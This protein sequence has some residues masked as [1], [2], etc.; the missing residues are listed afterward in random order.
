MP[1]PTP[2]G[3]LDLP[4]RFAIRGGRAATGPCYGQSMTT[5][6]LFL[7]A[8]ALALA[9]A[10]CG[11]ASPQPQACTGIGCN[12][13][14]QITLTSASAWKAG[15]YTVEVVSDGVTTT[16]TATLPLTSASTADCTKAGVQIGLSGSML[17]P[18]QQSL[19]DILLTAT[20]KA[21]TITLSRDGAQLVTKSFTPT[22]K[23]SRPNGPDCE[24]TCTS[25]SDTLAL[26]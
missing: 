12:I 20:P 19:S 7:F 4:V 10:G 26:P 13:G 24:P 17:P 23:T 2:A 25:A 9:L 8:F 5:R 21:V 15:K 6:P 14:Y 1:D 3:L 22:Y 11:V 16:C 18:E